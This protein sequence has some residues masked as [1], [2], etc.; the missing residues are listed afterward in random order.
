MS[1]PKNLREAIDSIEA[2]EE[3]IDDYNEDILELAPEFVNDERDW[4]LIKDAVDN[5]GV[6]LEPIP[7]NDSDWIIGTKW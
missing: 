3:A 5:K 6:N 7:W 4:H 1:I 2:A